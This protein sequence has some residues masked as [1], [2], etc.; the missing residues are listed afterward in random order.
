[1]LEIT[2]SNR[3]KRIKKILREFNNRN[4]PGSGDYATIK[5]V[6]VTKIYDFG[7]YPSDFQQFVL[8]VGYLELATC[9]Y[10]ALHVEYPIQ[11]SDVLSNRD[12]LVQ[13]DRLVE[14]VVREGRGPEVELISALPAEVAKDPDRFVIVAAWPCGYE[15]MG[16][17]L[18]VQP[19]RPLNY[20]GD[21]IPEYGA[22]FLDFVEYEINN[23]PNLPDL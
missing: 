5:K 13:D 17:D 7:N 14:F 15:V 20:F 6:D 11:V 4:L 21:F 1:M 12:L 10:A 19:Y 9:G 3:I 16:F 2:V 22:T 18:S 23:N 8:E